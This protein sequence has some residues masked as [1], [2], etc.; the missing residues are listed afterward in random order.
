MDHPWRVAVGGLVM[1]AVVVVSLGY[2]IPNV[3]E[4]TLVHTRAHLFESIGGDLVGDGLA[5]VATG[6]ATDVDRLDAA[7]RLRLI[8]SDV[9]RVI[10]WDVAGRARYSDAATLVGTTI[11][12]LDRLERAL[13]GEMVAGDPDSNELE[14]ET[15]HGLESVREYYVPVHDETG[16]VVGALEFYESADEISATMRTTRREVWIS[17][18]V[19]LGVVLGF[20]L[21]LTG[22]SRRVL[23]RRREQAERLVAEMAE[24]QEEERERVIGTL[25][26]EIAQPLYRVLYGIEG[27]LA[28][29][30]AGGAVSD[31]LREVADVVRWIDGALRSELVMLTQGSIAESDLDTLLD[32]LVDD[33]RSGS[34]LRVEITIDEHRPVGEGSRA[35]LFRAVRE[36]VTNVRRHA[37]AE[38][39]QIRVGADGDRVVAEV[40]DDGVGYAGDVGIGLRTTR[41]RLMAIGGDLKVTALDEGGTM[42]RAWVPARGEG[43]TP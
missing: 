10:L 12:H 1:A 38:S 37:A 43:S 14:F 26:D 11:P 39:V 9:V 21:L 32:R 33:V 35:A 17:I 34:G 24:A 23:D 8:G 41:D 19:G 42:F 20:V 7:V 30:E 6:T 22:A 2:L 36:A 15:R 29:L 13:R 3:V 16:A 27:S 18:A 4:S 28:E 40:R 25:H 31:D 5:D